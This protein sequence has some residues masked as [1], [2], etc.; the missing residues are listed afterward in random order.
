MRTAP[1]NEST[2]K[3]RAI[4][5][6]SR[7][8]ASALALIIC[9][10]ALACPATG[11]ADLALAENG[12]SDYRI[13]IAAEA[14][15][16]T[17]HAAGE[18]QHFLERM[19]GARLPVVADTAPAQEHEILVG[20]SR[21]ANE[22]GI[23]IDLPT[24]GKEG[25]VIRTIGGRLVI[26]GGEPR[27]T[28]YGVYGLLED[29]MGC[30]WFTPEID[31]IPMTPR[32]ALPQ[33]DE[34]RVPAFE[35]RETY[36]WE[37]YDGN[38][39]ARNRLNGAG[40]RGR[41]LERQGIRPPMPE[42]DAQH[43]G[44]IRFGFG[45]FVH[46]IEKLVSAERY[47]SAHPEYFAL[48]EGRRDPDQVCCTNEDVIRLC[49]EAI[50]QGMR[51]QPKATVFSLSQNDNK[52]YCRCDRCA[53]LAKSEG[54][55]MAQILHLVNRVAEA[56]YREF[57]DKIIETL[58]YQ[59]TRKPPASMSP[60]RNVVIRLCDIE[61]C[62][63]HPLASNCNDRNRAFVDDLRAWA[64]VCDRLWIWDYTTNYSHYLL[65]MPN[66]RLLDDNI[67]L[68]A[69]NHVTG[70][71]EQGTYDT[72]DSEM[73]ALK[74]YLI[75]KFLWDPQY[76]ENRATGE[77][78]DA[79]Y[80]AAASPIRR[81]LDLIHDYAESH[82]AHV[83]IFVPPAHPH[84]TPDLLAKA[85]ALWDEAEAC[86]R[87]T[88][89]ALDRVRRS[90]MSVDYAIVEQAR[91]AAKIPEQ[92]RTG[93]Q[94]ALMTLARA[95]LA[96]FTG[97][98][99]ASKLTRIRE[100]KDCDKAEYREK[101]AADLG[102]STR[103][104][105]GSR[106]LP[107]APMGS[108]NPWPRFRF[109]IRQMPIGIPGDLGAE[110][111]AGM[112]TN[113]VVPPLPYLM[114]DSY[115]R[116]RQ[117]GNLP[118]IQAENA[119]LRATFYPSLGGRM[120]SLYDKRAGRE[121]L[122]DNPVLQF[123][124]L[125][126]R[127]AWFSG[128]VEWNGPL[129]GHSLL[130]C[131]P[132]FA[133]VVETPRGPLLRLYEFDRALETTWQVDVFLPPGDDRLWVHVKAINPNAHDIDFYWWTN[134][135]LPLA[136]DTRVLSPMDYALS[137]DATG[138]SRLPFPIF[139][140][141]D[142][143]HPSN[144]PYAKSVF[145]RKPGSAKPWSV[146]VDGDGL[147][148]CHVSTPTLFGRKF[149]TWG[150]G[151]GGK[152]WMDFLSEDGR[153]DYIEIQGGVTPTQLQTRPLKAG[154]HI[155]W[156]ECISPFEMDTAAARDPDYAA[157]CA[158]A[159]R[160]IDARV[161]ATKLQEMD[162]FLASQ[163]IAP[164]KEL[165]HRGSAWGWLHEKRTG[166]RISP[167]L[168]FECDPGEEERPWAELLASGTFLPKTLNEPP[169]SFVVSVGWTEALRD[170]AQTHG[171]TW[172]HHI[173][174][175][176]ARLEAGDFREA[177]DFFTSSLAL[178]ESALAHRC[179]ALLH[180]RDGHLEDARASYDRAWTLCGNDPNFAIE[181]C[182]FLA[183]HDRHAAFSAFAKSLPPHIA[184]HERIALMT[185][186]IALEQ[187]DYPAVRKLLDREFCTIREGEQSLSELW[188]ASYIREAEA[189]NGRELTAAERS[190]IM[191]DFPPPRQIDFRMK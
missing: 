181:A 9:G 180:E 21:R 40:G 113:A 36:T 150:T 33:V 123:A 16:S 109:L 132:V 2:T 139:D 118:A 60:R 153:G 122:F 145:F 93:E 18:L 62:F 49:T 156:T 77:F 187:G 83:G 79:Y 160:I 102:I 163:A 170:S 107:K 176:V 108:P 99:A 142:G 12:G 162:T 101:L 54:T 111:R 191:Q 189:R 126:I 137:H 149:F 91:A 67:R 22:L 56:A 46:T 179:L 169:S 98:M 168:S 144:Y 57:P 173:H 140:G 50:L 52:K 141:F 48:W 147:G 13:V 27:G 69:A 39:M 71:F 175:G 159:G 143:S 184:G 155:E 84:L 117:T 15:P 11:R 134:I 148:L 89:D 167:G 3:P 87:G 127:N 190:Q 112:F 30:R 7:C 166:H 35:Y 116:R 186:Q 1:R 85:N 110:D 23:A 41:L 42:L 55:Q 38:W 29:H 146:C 95:R 183:R 121:L 96:P 70:V 133:G 164:L 24:L 158:G 97:T 78:L 58:A 82:S 5:S 28:L 37:S 135:A 20:R 66:K 106:T 129:Y 10:A 81:Y 120:I 161:P 26:A 61:C 136:R 45:F 32:L 115:S 128:G 6:T 178:K 86:A 8:L 34:R 100:W 88:S 68:F 65:P 43:G 47:F 130:T 63:S 174:L 114:Q 104:T 105:L 188:F 72:P 17:R 119:A 157:A 138:N 19:T 172:L 90:R 154:A 94:R 25:Y 14:P 125:A 124:N 64:K 51:E 76:D 59:W 103:V 80:G 92:D 44:D 75:A 4:S 31:R 185:A 182:D 53:A 171:A 165:L 152:R 151:R 131:S 177:R 74:S 73:V